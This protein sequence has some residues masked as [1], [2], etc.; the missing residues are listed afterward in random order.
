MYE[1]RGI[2][3]SIH[4][5]DYFGNFCVLCN[6]K[7]RIISFAERYVNLNAEINYYCYY[8]K[9]ISWDGGDGPR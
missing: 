5:F 1:K 9:Y 8:N 6:Y 3:H 4:K 2:Y 7:L